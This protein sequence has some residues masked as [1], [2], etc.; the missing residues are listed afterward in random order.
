MVN[1]LP[2]YDIGGVNSK[3]LELDMCLIGMLRLSKLSNS[4]VVLSTKAD[5]EIS[6]NAGKPVTI[7]MGDVELDRTPRKIVCF[8][9]K[10]V[11]PETSNWVGL[12]CVSSLQ[13]ISSFAKETPDEFTVKMS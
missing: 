8:N 2:S 10:G 13:S 9:C 6:K 11:E 3:T 7:W 5:V 1:D 12:V 4:P